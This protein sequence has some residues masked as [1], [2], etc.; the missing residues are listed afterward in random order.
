MEKLSNP[1]VPQH[2]LSASEMIDSYARGQISYEE[3]REILDAWWEKNK[4]TW[5]ENDLLPLFLLCLEN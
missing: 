1:E 4:E 3:Y 2:L 5:Q